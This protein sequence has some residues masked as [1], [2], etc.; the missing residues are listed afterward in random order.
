MLYRIAYYKI[1]GWYEKSLT[2]Y[3]LSKKINQ[4]RK[5]SKKMFRKKIITMMVVLVSLFALSSSSFSQN[6]P[7]DKA[8]RTADMLYRKLNLSDDQYSKV[9]TSLLGYYT[10][11]NTYM[12]EFKG[13]KTACDDACKKDWDKVNSGMSSVLNKDQMAM[14]TG[15]NQKNMMYAASVRYH[16]KVEKTPETSTT[17]MSKDPTKK[18]EDTKKD[19]TKKTDDTKKE[20]KKSTDKK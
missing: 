15:M 7:G 19:V 16:K 3:S 6:L 18:T 4:N 5:E 12:K 14:Y 8:G 9:Y 13:N 1:F 17:D 20:V 11:Q 10:N 2:E